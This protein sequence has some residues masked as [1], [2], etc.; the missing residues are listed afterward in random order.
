MDDKAAA[1]R[2]G[3]IEHSVLGENDILSSHDQRGK[4]KRR[5]GKQA[6][7]DAESTDIV[8][9]VMNVLSSG[10][11]CSSLRAFRVVTLGDG[12]T[13]QMC[14]ALSSN[15]T[16]AH[17][18]CEKTQATQWTRSASGSHQCLRESLSMQD[19]EDACSRSENPSLACP[20]GTA[21]HHDADMRRCV[22]PVC[23][24]ADL[25]TCCTSAAGSS[26]ANLAMDWAEKLYYSSSLSSEDA[27]KSARMHDILTVSPSGGQGYPLWQVESEQGAR[28]GYQVQ[29]GE[30]TK[31]YVEIA[32]DKEGTYWKNPTP[33]TVSFNVSG[34][35]K[36]ASEEFSCLATITVAMEACHQCEQ[37]TRGIISSKY[38]MELAQPTGHEEDRNEQQNLQRMECSTWFLFANTVMSAKATLWRVQ[39]MSHNDC[40]QYAV[41]QNAR[42]SMQMDTTGQNSITADDVSH[43]NRK[44]PTN[45][46]SISGWLSVWVASASY[47]HRDWIKDWD[48][49]LKSASSEF[50]ILNLEYWGV[51]PNKHTYVPDRTDQV[52]IT[53]Q[54]LEKGTQAEPY[55][56]ND[57]FYEFLVKQQ[58]A[59]TGNKE[60][61]ARVK[62]A[63][64]TCS[65][66]IE[67]SH[68]MH[69]TQ[70]RC[71]GWPRDHDG[72][73]EVDCK[74]SHGSGC[75]PDSGFNMQ[76]LDG[77]CLSEVCST[78]A[79][80]NC[81][82]GYFLATFDITLLTTPTSSGCHQW[83]VRA[84]AF[85]R[86]K[87]DARNS[88]QSP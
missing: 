67:G 61:G 57:D 11:P 72:G 52:K 22:G 50:D 36:G 76:N 53:Y 73:D 39:M 84:D 4:R 13:S 5:K 31:Y 63:G 24:Q 28:W 35:I 64:H 51:K 86:I 9:E 69:H 62:I 45:Y 49:V 33:S 23:T 44:I 15:T 16:G 19:A 58:D 79:D 65:H 18:A 20:A 32:V 26:Y 83:F 2:L 38:T 78:V 29:G 3:L 43:P 46:R 60:C 70:F 34:Q 85:L 42:Q 74:R 59:G 21:L 66:P 87:V 68:A 88:P 6:K 10:A 71:T 77:E 54:D 17:S 48:A 30:L 80:G 41:G 75:T 40:A 1:P 27:E 56:S 47:H 82:D 8:S 12:R 55:K 37:C 14:V 25:S 7:K 81:P